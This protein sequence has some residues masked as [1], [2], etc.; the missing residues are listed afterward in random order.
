MVT[1]IINNKTIIL[2]FA[3]NTILFCNFSSLI[4]SSCLLLLYY[5]FIPNVWM[6]NGDKIRIVIKLTLALIVLTT[7]FFICIIVTII[8]CWR[9]WFHLNFRHLLFEIH[10]SH[11][12]ILKCKHIHSVCR[13]NEQNPFVN[14]SKCVQWLCFRFFCSF[15]FVPCHYFSES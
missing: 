4:H 12:S 7:P 3:I 11:F 15:N 8:C 5:F 14:H 10:F 2:P 9:R 13:V 6:K 1:R